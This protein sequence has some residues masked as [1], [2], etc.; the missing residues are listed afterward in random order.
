MK[1]TVVLAYSGGL[2]T[3]CL[4]KWLSEK[5]FEVI[6]YMADIGQEKDYSKYK[7]RALATGAKKLIV[8]DLKKSFIRDY[9]FPSLK[10]NAVYE[11]QYF[12]ATALS[13]PLIAENMVKCAHRE[14]AGYLAH[15]CTGKGNDQ[16][17]FEISIK[18]V[19]PKLKVLAPLREWELTTRESEIEYAKSR[20]I[21]LEVTKKKP[22]SIDVNLWGISIEGGSLEDPAVAPKDDIYR[23]TT[24]P[25]RAPKAPTV[26]RISFVGGV[27]QKIDGKI[28]SAENLIRRLSDI[29]G[30]Y[31]V[32]RS[33]M[34]E[35]RLVGIKSREI[36]EAPAATVLFGAHRALESLVLDREHMHYKSGVELK[37]AELIYDGLWFTPLRKSLDAFIDAT[38]RKVTGDVKVKFTAGRSDVISRSSL[39]SLYKKELATYS[40]GDKFD[41][42][43]AKGFIDL[44]GLPYHGC[45]AK[46]RN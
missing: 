40:S 18:A 39:Y 9:I 35:N 22:Y 36:Y 3:S 43:L 23:L 16:V 29:A 6:A 11:N 32:G 7:K 25:S 37:Y 19:D 13:R 46:G 33:D 17:R 14:G 38:Q 15:G 34:V 42:R 2:D 31:G 41:Q 24:S 44:M 8:E 5:G 12:L 30:R 10:A 21:P 45:E 28:L 4:V 1:K 27:P 26:I 20:G